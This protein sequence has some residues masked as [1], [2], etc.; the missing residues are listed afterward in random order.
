MGFFRKQPQG[1]ILPDHQGREE[2]ACGRRTRM[3]ESERDHVAFPRTEG[4]V[5]KPIRRTWRRLLGSLSGGRRETELAQEVE[6]HIAML[7]EANL[8]AGMNPEE[9]RRAAALKFGGVDVMKE[10]YRDQRGLPWLETTWT[11]LRYAIRTLRKN[12]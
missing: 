2:G 10:E 6:A 5:M 9:A 3:G 7:T 1:Q 8:R 11:D 4:V 12:P